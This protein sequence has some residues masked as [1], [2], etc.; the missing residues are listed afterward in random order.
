MKGIIPR[1]SLVDEVAEALRA[2]IDSG[3]WAV[4]TRIPPEAE[5]AERLGVSRTAIREGVR[6]LVHAGLLQPRQGVG[7]YVT[8]TNATEV[9]LQRR[10]SSALESDVLSVR[11]GLDVIAA[12]L[13]AVH[14]SPSDLE[15][16]RR[17]LD[18]RR[19]AADKQDEAAFVEADVR[20]HLEIARASENEVL[21]ELYESLSRSLAQSVSGDHCLSRFGADGTDW[22]EELFLRI[23]DQN[24]QAAGVAALALVDASSRDPDTVSEPGPQ[25]R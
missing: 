17:A 13:A 8:A 9:A 24:E 21:A 1:T 4:G 16:L 10:L 11:R 25:I 20:F 22:H 14:R 2:E 3:T 23:Q 12:R 5:L 18:E 7:T 15:T 19:V 6:G